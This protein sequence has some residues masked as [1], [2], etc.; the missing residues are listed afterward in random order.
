MIL[1]HG[2]GS[3]E[4][5]LPG[6]APYLPPLPWASVRAPLAMPGGGAAWFPLALPEEPDPQDIEA[7]TVGLWDWIDDNV[8]STHPLVPVGFSQGGLMALQL[9]R[10][11]PE[12]VAATVVLA[13][14]VPTG[15][16]PADARLAE[17]RPPVFW[18]RGDADG[19]IW[20]A[21]IAR[22][23]ALLP[24]IADLTERTYSGLGHGVDERMLGD[25][26]AFLDAHVDSGG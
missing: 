18:G 4:R 5:D 20:P 23:Q 12:R 24:T 9:L 16:Q 22:T 3:H 25:V 13:G 7:A 6:L 8:P 2:Y 15:P 1:L 10:T 26:R 21:A 19:V 17:R 11:R 14:F